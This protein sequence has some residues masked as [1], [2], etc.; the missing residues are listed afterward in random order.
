MEEKNMRELNMNELE[1][2]SGGAGPF[3]ILYTYIE[4]RRSRTAPN[5]ICTPR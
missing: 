3:E 5:L 2:V 1:K 4:N